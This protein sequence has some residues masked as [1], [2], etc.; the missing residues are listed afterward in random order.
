MSK[1]TELHLLRSH[2]G[3]PLL[4]H[5]RGVSKRASS[6]AEEMPLN[7]PFDPGLLVELAGLCGHYHDVAKSTPYFQEYLCENRP[8]SGLTAHALPSAVVAFAAARKV[9]ATIDEPWRTL[10]PAF[11]FVAVRAHHG[12]LKP[13][14]CGATLSETNVLSQQ[15]SA[16]HEG[17]AN[18]LPG[19]SEALNEAKSLISKWPLKSFKLKKALRSLPEPSVGYLVLNALFSCLIDADKLTTTLVD[20]ALPSRADLPNDLIDRYRR[21]H[22]FPDHKLNPL[23]EQF[24]NELQESAEETELGGCY[25]ITAPTGIGKTLAVLNAALVLRNRIEAKY[26]YRPRIVYALP[27]LSVIDQNAGELAK[28]VETTI[29]SPPTTDLLLTHHHLSSRQYEAQSE[30]DFSDAG[31]LL[32]E[33]WNSELVITT[34]H[35]VFHTLVG[36]RNRNLRRY[37]NLPGSILILD[38]VQSIPTKYWTLTSHLLKGITTHAS[39]LVLLS[40]ATQPAILEGPRELISDPARY[41][42]HETLQRTRISYEPKPQKLADLIAE[43]KQLLDNE[44]TDTL[45]VLNTI[46]D[47]RNAYESLAEVARSVGYQIFYLTTQVTPK[48]RLKRIESVRRMVKSRR[49]SPPENSQNIEGFEESYKPVLVFSTQLIEA[50]VDIDVARIV[51]DAA[52]FDSILQAAGRANRH[53]E[54]ADTSE[55]RTVEALGERFQGSKVYDSTLLDVTR[56]L[57]KQVCPLEERNYLGAGQTYVRELLPRIDQNESEQHIAAIRALD[58]D[59]L[60]SFK[61]VEDGAESESVF[62]ELDEAA[63]AL[64]Q[65]YETLAEVKDRWERRR[66]FNEFRADFFQYVIQVR[67]RQLQENLPP[68]VNGLLYVSRGDLETHY[69]SQTGFKVESESPCW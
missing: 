45:V 17:L 30:Y 37:H 44:I 2:P 60:N 19:G 18:T 61:L 10:L 33:G 69:D 20:K 1:D 35:Q 28:V 7:L 52:P 65:R 23:R 51:R 11:V 27:F 4:Q 57:L 38:E 12:S 67:V 39:G 5:L 16:I 62:I 42:K 25:T 49:K 41:Y 68:T 21:L 22:S 29:G 40:T 58:Y 9:C 63:Q 8:K 34:F 50:G 15:L 36:G 47:V 64:W 43:L 14:I 3:V 13:L 56:Q 55:I 66:Q 53:A 24:Y 54:R 46:R 26:S 59:T 48:E 31:E 32:V 6:F